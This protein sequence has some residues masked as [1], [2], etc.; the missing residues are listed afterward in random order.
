MIVSKRLVFGLL[1]IFLELNLKFIHGNRKNLKKINKKNQKVFRAKNQYNNIIPITLPVS[2]ENNNIKKN[3]LIEKPDGVLEESINIDGLF[4]IDE[5]VISKGADFLFALKEDNEIFN[6]IEVIENE[7]ISI[8]DLSILY[9]YDNKDKEAVYLQN[10]IEKHAADLLILFVIKSFLI[11]DN[12]DT[13]VNNKIKITQSE[14]KFKRKYHKS[15]G[16]KQIKLLEDNV[17]L[18][19]KIL[20]MLILNILNDNNDIKTSIF[21]K[22]IKILYPKNLFYNNEILKKQFIS[23]LRKIET[24]NKKFHINDY[25]SILYFLAYYIKEQ[26]EEFFRFILDKDF[27]RFVLSNFDVQEKNENKNIVDKKKLKETNEDLINKENQLVKELK[28]KEFSGIIK[29]A[30]SILQDLLK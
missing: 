5:T 6:N 14:I 19:K 20:L 25:E 28:I 23:R 16:Y 12:I 26:P 13:T 1:M 8:G 27:L 15:N 18:Y 21:D 7:K 4:E 9:T 22:F 3:L 24:I 2:I 17:I 11:K 29:Y 10:F 30:F